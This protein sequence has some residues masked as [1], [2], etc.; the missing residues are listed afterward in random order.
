MKR[1]LPIA[2]LVV[3][4][5]LAA[6]CGSSSQPPTTA[7][8]ADGVC[9]SIT[10]WADSVRSAVDPIASGDVSKDSLQGAADDVKSATDTL[11]S[12]LKDL[13][14]PDTAAGQQAKSSID[15]LSSELSANADSIKTAV[16]GV[17]G[18]SG[19][20]SAVTTVT[21]TLGTMKTEISSTYTSL[22]QLDAKGEL[23]TAFEQSSSCQ[24]LSGALSTSS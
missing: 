23:Q 22:K 18:V 13:G 16:D 17:S 21:T 10:T 15:Q 19:I 7:E 6:G 24:S 12:D 2:T 1:L 8:W 11:G 20:A 5:V 14:K 3:V 4:A 9:T